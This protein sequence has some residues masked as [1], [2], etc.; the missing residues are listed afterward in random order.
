MFECSSRP[1]AQRL[2]G[3]LDILGLSLFWGA[4]D[5]STD[6]VQRSKSP[7]SLASGALSTTRSRLLNLSTVFEP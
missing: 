3:S 7:T 1:V 4:H 6:E 2:Y 5:P